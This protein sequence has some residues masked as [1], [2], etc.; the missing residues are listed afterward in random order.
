MDGQIVSALVTGED[1][2]NDRWKKREKEQG[3]Q[4][5][6]TWSRSTAQAFDVSDI[7][8]DKELKRSFCLGEKDEWI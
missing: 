6:I 3:V 2:M 4:A 5:M 8:A 1:T 7:K